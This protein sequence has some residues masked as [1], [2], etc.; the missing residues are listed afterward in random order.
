MNP[1]PHQDLPDSWSSFSDF[2]KDIKPGQIA[3]GL[4]AALPDVLFWVKD[5]ESRFVF[6][7]QAYGDLLGI[8]PAS[9]VGK[10]DTDLFAAEIA[11]VFLDD[12]AVITKNGKPIY[13]KMEL[14]TR[15][16]GGVEWRMTSKIPL[17]A[18]DNKLMGTAGISRKLDQREGHPLPPPFRAIARLVEYVHENVSKPLTVEELAKNSGMSISTLERRFRSHL[19]TSPKKFILHSKTTAAC[20][21]LLSTPMTVNEISQSLGYTEHASFTRTFTSVMHMSPTAYRK[22]YKSSQP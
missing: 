22:Y 2:V 17:F 12:D 9:I 16:A 18:N 20:E 8:A 5:T 14:V 10:T 3:L 4:F 7:N 21:L 11:R 19:G 15:R 13:N 6:V 1:S